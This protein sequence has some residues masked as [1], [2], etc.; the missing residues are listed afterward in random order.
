[1]KEK[2]H[3]PTNKNELLE[4]RYTQTEADVAKSN[5]TKTE[6]VASITKWRCC[7]ELIKEL[8]S[9][10]VINRMISLG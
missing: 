5:E 2:T 1:M 10:P 8:F 3:V 7:L 6:A 4:W 9:L